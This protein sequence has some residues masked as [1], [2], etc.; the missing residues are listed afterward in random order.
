MSD[1]GF[2]GHCGAPLLAP[3]Q[4]FCNKCGAQMFRP[5]G[6]ASA[7]SSF[8]LPD[9]EESSGPSTPFLLFIGGLVVIAIFAVSNLASW[10][11]SQNSNTNSGPNANPTSAVINNTPVSPNTSW[12][13]FLSHEASF[14][15]LRQTDNQ[16]LVTS[17]GSGDKNLITTASSNYKADLETEIS[18]IE[19][20]P[21]Q[22]CY[23]QYQSDLLTSDKQLATA[24]DYN[25]AGDTSSAMN[26]MSTALDALNTANAE[27]DATN[28][29]CTGS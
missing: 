6:P 9:E 22:P 23:R 28:V 14:E 13:N 5:S 19:S 16:T 29:A 26:Y 25:I 24:M 8:K 4:S 1:Y 12:A 17:Q 15:N 20:H 2:C 7:F 11:S 21:P 18:W 3:D 10:S 27:G